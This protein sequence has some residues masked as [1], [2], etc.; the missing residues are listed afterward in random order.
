MRTAKIREWPYG[1][2][3][4]FWN[5]SYSFNNAPDSLEYPTVQDIAGLARTIEYVLAN[6]PISDR[7]RTILNL[8]YR[9]RKSY[10]AIGEQY[11][12]TG[13]RIRQICHNGMR[14]IRRS[15]RLKTM[16]LESAPEYKEL[17]KAH[18]KK[19]DPMILLEKILQGDI[20]LDE[21]D[22]DS[23][24]LFALSRSGHRTVGD[25]LA[26]KEKSELMEIYNFGEKSY[27]AVIKALEEKGYDVG[28]LK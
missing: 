7:E 20:L 18:R 13:Q 6:A 23:R 17:D 21:L 25:V 5:Y 22:L 2:L 14:K 19:P 9:D 16:L 3:D 8:R 11:G 10:N 28:H 1:F 4:D 12:I 15:P 24:S 27:E 26:H